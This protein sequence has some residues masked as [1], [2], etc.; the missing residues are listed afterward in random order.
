[1]RWTDK[2]VKWLG[3][4]QQKHAGWMA[5]TIENEALKFAHAE[6]ASG[7]KPRLAAAGIR[8]LEG[9]GS[10]ERASKSLHADR[11]QCLTVL[12]PKDYQLMLVDAPNVPAIELKKAI[13]WQVKDLL[14]YHVDDAT[15]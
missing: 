3:R 5:I 7:D 11:R 14:D 4:T 13:R 8:E 9:P 6:R 1:M 12:Q 2:T 10:E 15:I